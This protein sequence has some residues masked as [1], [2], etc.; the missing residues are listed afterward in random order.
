MNQQIT[1]LKVKKSQMLQ[2]A[3]RI[4]S[5]AHRFQTDKAGSPYILHCLRVMEKG[6]NMDEKIC[7]VLHD[8][9]EDTDWSFERLESEGFD[10]KIINALKCIT[11]LSEEE[12]YDSFIKRVSRNP[13][14]IRVKLNDLD[15]NMD[16]KRLTHITEKDRV[17]LNK[18]LKAFHYLKSIINDK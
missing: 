5:D 18:Y 12:D 6:I 11:K 2:K 16:V 10:E 3:I 15:D 8:L 7:G 13:L 14:A 1:E 4:A 9:I 17:R